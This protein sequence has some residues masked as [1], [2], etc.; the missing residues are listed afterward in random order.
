MTACTWELPPGL[1]RARWSERLETAHEL[2]EAPRSPAFTID[3]ANARL[4]LARMVD[5]AARKIEGRLAAGRG[6]LQDDVGSDRWLQLPQDK[7][8]AHA[9]L[10]QLG[11]DR[12]QAG[13]DPDFAWNSN[14]DA[15]VLAAARARA[16]APQGLDDEVALRG[17]VGLEGDGGAGADAHARQRGA[18]RGHD[19][20][21]QNLVGKPVA[22]HLDHDGRSGRK[23][24]RGGAEDP[25]VRN[26]GKVM[27]LELLEVPAANAENVHGG[28]QPGE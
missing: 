25:P 27:L 3:E 14:G 26:V 21:D 7:A 2:T 12:L 22:G 4:M 28:S 1:S 23:L 13:G 18:P 10:A 24:G 15:G 8:A 5:D 19:A 17:F 9:D 20:P 6:D 16:L 11:F